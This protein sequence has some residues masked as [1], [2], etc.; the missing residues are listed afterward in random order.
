VVDLAD[1]DAA[2]RDRVRREGILWIASG[3]APRCASKALLR[4]LQQVAERQGQST[5]KLGGTARK[6]G[7]PI[8]MAPNGVFWN[9]SFGRLGAA[10]SQEIDD[11]CDAVGV[12]CIVTGHTPHAGFGND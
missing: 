6:R 7:D 8:F 11:M 2:F 1:S 12:D 5:A 3:S 10:P 9:R 4:H